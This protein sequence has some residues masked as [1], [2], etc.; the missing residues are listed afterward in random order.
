MQEPKNEKEKPNPGKGKTTAMRG[1]TR[2]CEVIKQYEKEWEG[3]EARWKA[4]NEHAKCESASD[5][6]I[7]FAV[8]ERLADCKDKNSNRKPNDLGNAETCAFG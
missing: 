8:E 4:K 2:I 3:E 5:F 6:G 7:G 1:Q